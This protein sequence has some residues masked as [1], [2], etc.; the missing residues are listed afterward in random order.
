[1]INEPL[2]FISLDGNDW[3]VKPYLGLSW[4][5]QN[6]VQPET[7]EI[8]YFMPARVPGSV[9]ADMIRAGEVRD[10]FW[11][12]QSLE[13][14]WVPARQWVF[15]KWFTLTKKQVVL[16]AELV[17][18][19]LDY[20]ADI[21]L[22][23]QPVGH[24]IGQ[25]S[26]CRLPVGQYLVSGKNLL[27]I[28]LSEAPPEQPQ[29]GRTSLTRTMKSRMTY[30]WDFCPRMIHVG[31]WDHVFLDL[32]GPARLCDIQI[33]S[34]L[35]DD[36]REAVLTV[37]ATC[38][39]ADGAKLFVSIDKTKT[40]S[41][42]TDNRAVCRLVLNDPKLWFPA[43]SGSQHR[44]RVCV[45]LMAQNGVLSDRRSIRHG[46]RR[47][48]WQK[49]DPVRPSMISD[50]NK[51]GI[52]PSFVLTVNGQKTYIKG[53]NWVPID[54]MYGESQPERLNHL[55]ALAKQA[56]INL[57]RVWG[58]GLI[59]KD[60][61]Y[62]ACAE[63]GI[64]IWQEFPFSSS[65]IDNKTPED[66]DFL[67]FVRKEATAIVKQKRNH[68]ALAVWC[69]GNELQ[70]EKGRPLDIN[71]P[72]LALLN[73]IVSSLDPSRRFLPTSPSG[74]VFEYCLENAR[75]CP[76]Q[77]IDVH[78][79][80]EHQGIN[81]HYVLYQSARGR[82]HSEF[83]V[84]SMAHAATINATIAP[85]DQIPPSLDH[86]VYRHKGSF[87]NN[88][89]LVLSLFGKKE[90]EGQLDRIRMA[91]MYL[92]YEGLKYAL[93]RN[94]SDAFYNSGSLPWQFNEPYPN[95]W[96]TS[97]I[98]YY[99]RPKPGYYAACHAY[100]SNVICASFESASL[101]GQNFLKAGLD[102]CHDIHQHD[103]N[104]SEWNITA[105]LY[106][107]DGLVID[108]KKRTVISC[109]QTA[110][111]HLG[112]VE[113]KLP[114]IT[115]RQ[116]PD[117]CFVLL[118]LKA[119]SDQK[120]LAENTYLFTLSD[121]YADLWHCSGSDIDVRGTGPFLTIRNK[122]CFSV[123]WLHIIDDAQ[124]GMQSNL[125]ISP[126]YFVLLPGEEKE[127]QIRSNLPNKKGQ[128]ENVHIESFNTSGQTISVL[129]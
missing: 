11:N 91:S 119:E 17:L 26:H 99:G 123:L 24:H 129:V 25:F 45:D 95:A 98:D 124:P 105:T 10:P 69:G 86:P 53:Y 61:F 117:G 96:C 59:E 107:L 38:R 3:S 115:C 110:S 54:A 42:V 46:I 40:F 114:D 48:E 2:L 106:T 72:L 67:D 18:M 104:T 20:E 97:S 71:D 77:L 113:L 19:G 125:L 65:G 7:R 52:E 14:E 89:E 8:R 108:E 111:E 126:N 4:I 93:E 116:Q 82:L 37:D 47:I 118:R 60:I 1:M 49:N 58:G 88:Y 44:Y 64:M 92:Q 51:T 127:I 73:S 55:I 102:L 33:S 21:F 109:F 56:G 85:E 39:N 29:L 28:V 30:G 103:R 128:R 70:D 35:S 13:A 87:W 36:L 22:N 83:G 31:I 41:D 78:G 23:G 120:R 121:N 27:A 101:F 84:E 80:W 75:N 9:L 100:R 5:W 57:F 6:A 34:Q 122:G 66:P 68:C 74:G 81:K 62:E 43:G 63:A 12:R 16:Q 15:R 76:D 50:L 94:R 112:T 32:S 79:P 90:L